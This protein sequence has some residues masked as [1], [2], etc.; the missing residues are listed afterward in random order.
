M[1]YV[2]LQKAHINEK[3]KHVQAIFTHEV[4][5]ITGTTSPPTLFVIRSN[6]SKYGLLINNLPRGLSCEHEKTFPDRKDTR[7]PFCCAS[8]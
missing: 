5:L 6:G 8:E 4:P 1:E 2:L 7:G 3:E